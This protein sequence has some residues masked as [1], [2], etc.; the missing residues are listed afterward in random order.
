[1]SSPVVT[2]AEMRELDRIAI[3]DAGIAGIVLMENA[4]RGVAEVVRMAAGTEMEAPIVCV[5]GKGNN[6]GDGF[7]V[8]RYLQNWGYEVFCILVGTR[9]QVT[10]DALTQLDIVDTLGV[11]VIELDDEWTEMADDALAV[12]GVVVD[13]LFGTGLNAVVDGLALADGA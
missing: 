4:G 7:V 2:A 11:E 3:E 10:G 9:D 13:A 5:C 12:A 8:A 1:M 6:G